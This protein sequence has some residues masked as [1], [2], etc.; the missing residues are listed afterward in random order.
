[1]LHAREVV[2][3][4][5]GIPYVLRTKFNNDIKYRVTET[6]KMITSLKGVILFGA[7]NASFFYQK[8]NFVSGRY[9]YYIDTRHLIEK[10]CLFLVSCLDTLTD[11]Y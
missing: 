2:E 7:K 9:I 6:K 11:K 3:D 4:E 8:E 5:N 10:T 1:M